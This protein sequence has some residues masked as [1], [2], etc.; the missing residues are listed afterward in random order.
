MAALYLAFQTVA[1]NASQPV[2]TA[3]RAGL[4]DCGRLPPVCAQRL[5][6]AWDNRSR[7]SFT[8]LISCTTGL[9]AKGGGAWRL[10][11]CRPALG[12]PRERMLQVS[13]FGPARRLCVVRVC[14][15]CCA[16]GGLV[17]P[18]A[19]LGLLNTTVRPCEKGA[20]A[21]GSWG[22]G[23]GSRRRAGMTGSHSPPR[24]RPGDGWRRGT[25][26]LARLRP[27]RPWFVSWGRCGDVFVLFSSLV[28]TFG[29]VRPTPPPP[30]VVQAT[31][32]PRAT[33]AAPASIVW[34]SSATHA[35]AW[36]NGSCLHT[37]WCSVRGRAGSGN[38]AGPRPF[39]RTL[40][41][42]CARAR[43]RACVRACWDSTLCASCLPV[44]GRLRA[45]P[46][47]WP[48]WGMRFAGA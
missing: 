41:G 35:Q 30:P 21:R 8:R 36:A 9:P 48:A 31:R 46:C 1:A 2:R 23:A 42:L 3:P 7:C 37:C 10:A 15:A 12:E 29:C 5:G 34:E 39:T 27:G 17:N 18:S 13:P 44:C 11:R 26:S 6:A 19:V 43:V 40:A 22:G 20:P 14:G 45:Q 47:W 28:D 32:A 4:R 33:A 38:G 25:G 24:P 16:Q